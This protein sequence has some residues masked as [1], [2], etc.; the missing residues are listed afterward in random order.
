MKKY[1]FVYFIFY[2][3][4]C[5]PNT[6]DYYICDDDRDAQSCSNSC[7]KIGLLKFNHEKLKNNILQI[8]Y[9]LSNGSRKTEYIEDCK[10]NVKGDWYCSIFYHDDKNSISDGYKI[11][12][13]IDGSYSEQYNYYDRNGK[14]EWFFGFGCAKKK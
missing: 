1:F 9:L 6:L 8:E 7:K 5:I 13:V 3:S 4:N 14:K 11:F 10:F 2:A 12:Q